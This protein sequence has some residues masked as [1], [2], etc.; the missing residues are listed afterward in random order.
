[1]IEA[2]AHGKQPVGEGL[3]GP[4]RIALLS[5]IS[6]AR[7]R[8]AIAK[9]KNTI[10]FVEGIVDQGEKVIVYS[11]FTPPSEMVEKHF[12][13]R[14]V[15]ITGKTPT[16]RRQ[17]IVDAFQN[18]DSVRVMAANIIAA[19]VGVNLT[20][21]RSVVFNDLDWV[22][23]NHWQ[24]E[25][26]AYRI[27][28]EHPV[29]VYYFSASGTL[30]EFMGEVLEA[31]SRLIVDVVDARALTSEGA[32]SADVLSELQRM[33]AR[34][35]GQMSD[36]ES[37][38]K[39]GRRPPAAGGRPALPGRVRRGGIL[40]GDP[41]RSGGRGRS[42]S[43][44]PRPSKPSRGRL[45]PLPPSATGCETGKGTTGTRSRWTG[46]T[47]RAAAADSTTGASAGTR[48]RWRRPCRGAGRI[49]PEFEPA[50]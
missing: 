13:D 9:V 48:G 28:Q 6:P 37:D 10:E 38:H 16:G 3:E 18:D 24:A 12:G 44:P 47:S 4:N 45:I 35:S 8:I 29:N 7:K 43:S 31:K 49:P 30:E 11:C 17:R 25:D 50:A 26:R 34:V 42:P 22:P 41:T 23:A 19:G 40:F 27:G 2:R 20:A 32:H 39:G 21:A 46:Q 1:M 14:A 36:E 5:R 15:K 33:I